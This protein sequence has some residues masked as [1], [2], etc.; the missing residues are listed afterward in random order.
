MVSLRAPLSS[1]SRT[2]LFGK[3]DGLKNVSWIQIR[4]SILLH[5]VAGIKSPTEGPQQ[6]GHILPQQKSGQERSMCKP[7][8]TPAQ[9]STVTR[10]SETYRQG[11]GRSILKILFPKNGQNS[12]G[13]GLCRGSINQRNILPC[14]KGMLHAKCWTQNPHKATVPF[15]NFGSK[16][17]PNDD[18]I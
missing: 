7:A 12:F 4:W 14:C 5:I 10:L 2:S 18:K 3:Y 11:F 15:D 17:V 16:Q 8:V 6:M 1:V 13:K 9:M